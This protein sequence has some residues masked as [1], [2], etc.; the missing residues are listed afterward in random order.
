MG[1]W[2]GIHQQNEGMFTDVK[3]YFRIVEGV[4]FVGG[5]ARRNVP[6]TLRVYGFKLAETQSRHSE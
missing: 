4:Y 6:G 1:P 2:T 3:Q 5:F